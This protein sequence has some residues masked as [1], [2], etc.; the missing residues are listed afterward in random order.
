MTEVTS[1]AK[2]TWPSPETTEC[3][4]PA[5]AALRAEAPIYKY[6]DRN[7]FLL[8]RWE[9]VTYV[10]KHP[11]LFSNSMFGVDPT[12]RALQATRATEGAPAG[13]YTAASMAS[14]DPPEHRLKRALGLNLVHGDRLRRYEPAVQE[15]VDEL[16]ERW[17]DRGRCDFRAEFAD[18]L[19]IHVIVDL[20]GL[21]REDVP[22]FKVW[23]ESEGGAIRYLPEE[24]VKVELEW[25][26]EAT[27]Y[28]REA[29]LERHERPRDDYLSEMIRQQIAQDGE[30]DLDYMTA[31]ANVMLFAG[32][33]TTAHM[34]ANGMVMLCRHPDEAER[35]RRDPGLLRPLI[36]EFL[37]LESPVQWLQ[38]VCL[39]D[40]EIGGVP[41]PAGSI[42]IIFWASGNRDE[43]RFQCPEQF[44][45]ER[46]NG[47][48][49]QLAFGHGIHLCLGAPLARL[50]LRIAFESLLARLSNLR[51][52]EEECDLRNVDS[53][54][55]RAP[56][57]L[58]VAF[59]RA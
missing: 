11:E 46:P 17:I 4:Y 20:L 47:A 16:I 42:L 35:V 6:P 56:R 58:V 22:R 38:R 32:N 57:R 49:H 21:P 52:V 15:L 3:P 28:M 37:R 29:M 1:L 43:A 40:T 25:A 55:M 36:E 53:V 30:F 8:T 39:Q 24:R 34:L 19:P 18:L 33:V 59:D 2:L 54:R 31:E 10:A 50:E 48:R 14:S 9:D 23:G 45:L 5:Y 41:I 26:A 7:E 12:F 51:L 27:A 44:D 13:R